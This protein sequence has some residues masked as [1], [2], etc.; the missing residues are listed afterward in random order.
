MKYMF[1]IFLHVFFVIVNSSLPSLL[2]NRL[3]CEFSL[4]THIHKQLLA[5]KIEMAKANSCPACTIY[6][7]CHKFKQKH[8]GFVASEEAFI[9][10][11]RPIVV[12]NK[13]FVLETNMYEPFPDT[14]ELAMFGMGCF[15]GVERLFWKLPG[16][17]STQVGYAGGF[18]LNPSYEEAYTG[19][20][21]H[22][23]VVR[24]VYDPQQISYR[25]LLKVF[26]EFHDPTQGLQ[27]GEDF[28][29]QYRSMI[30]V[31]TLDQRE[32][33]IAS[34][35]MYQRELYK[36]GLG[37]ITTEIRPVGEFYYAEEYHQQYLGKNPGGYCG[38]GGT[39]V[40][41]PSNFA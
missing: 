13:H 28:G 25:Q 37:S 1:W 11:S 18:T 8:T 20:T 30:S 4:K 6:D 40:K 7:E 5:E 22:N 14:F 3:F 16:V 35:N 23:E 32:E 29:S 33:A 24:I 27:Q 10:R 26:W 15:W 31:Y 19:Y 34:R 36:V 17:Y 9:G 12:P 38:I 39:G 21:G 2:S 41:L